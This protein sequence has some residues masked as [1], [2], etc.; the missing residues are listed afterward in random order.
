MPSTAPTWLAPVPVVLLGVSLLAGSTS[1]LTGT[2]ATARPRRAP[3]PATAPPP[4]DVAPVPA[5]PAPVVNLNTATAAQLRLLPRVGPALAERI[6][7]ARARRPFRQLGALRRIRGIGRVTLR[8]LAPHVVLVG[9][10]TATAKIRL[11]QRTAQHR[12]T[13]HLRRARGAPQ[14]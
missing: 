11:P 5:D 4:A 8:W 2:R 3:S 14:R 13:A 12:A 1:L 7:R 10:T 6:L 9:P